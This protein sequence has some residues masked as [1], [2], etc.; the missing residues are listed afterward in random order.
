MTPTV[1]KSAYWATDSKHHIHRRPEPVHPGV[2][3]NFHTIPSSEAPQFHVAIPR[4]NERL[5]RQD[6]FTLFGLLH[7]DGADLIQALGHG[8]GEVLR[9]VLHERIAEKLAGSL[10]RR[11]L[12]ASGPPIELPIPTM[13]PGATGSSAGAG[14]G[15]GR[16][17]PPIRAVA[18]AR[19][20]RM[21]SCPNASIPLSSLPSGFATKSTAP[22]SRADRVVFAPARVN[23]LTMMTGSGSV[24]IKPVRKTMPSSP[25]IFTSSVM[26]SGL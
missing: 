6:G 25:G 14:V 13:N 19:T 26:T 17:C 11:H 20:F 16:G 10:G 7:V 8:L 4:S 18:E 12:N 5:T 15:T 24:D 3:V 2:F 9:H 1:S 22:F 23:A 21:S